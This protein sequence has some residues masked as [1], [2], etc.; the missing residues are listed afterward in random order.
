MTGETT[1][2]VL[3]VGSVPLDTVDDVMTTCAGRLG[4]RL[5]AMPDGEV[6]DVRRGSQRC[7][8]W[9]TPATMTSKWFA[10]SLRRTSGVRP[11]TTP[12]RREPRSGRSGFGQ[13]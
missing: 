7:H 4:G 3:L 10:S 12:R 5:Y 11:L 6:G 13:G 8:T 1:G 9:L 2:D